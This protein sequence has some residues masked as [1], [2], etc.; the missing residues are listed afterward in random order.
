MDKPVTPEKCQAIYY[1]L[2]TLLTY[3]EVAPSTYL[4]EWPQTMRCDLYHDLSEVRRVTTSL[5][6]EETME[7]LDGCKPLD[8]IDVFNM[9]A[10][11][12]SWRALHEASLWHSLDTSHKIRCLLVDK[13]REY[14]AA[15]G[16]MT[17]PYAGFRAMLKRSRDRAIS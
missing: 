16:L 5:L 6:T 4:R 15:R 17:A 3:E 13:P 7:K 8:N 12:T 11:K 2:Y 10:T 14:L 9:N 1:N